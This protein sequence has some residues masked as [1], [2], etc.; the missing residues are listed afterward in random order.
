MH[1]DDTL[2]PR[3]GPH[4]PDLQPSDIEVRAKDTNRGVV[5]CTDVLLHPRASISSDM[6]CDLRAMPDSELAD[7][8]THF[9]CDQRLARRLLEDIGGPHQTVSHPESPSVA[10]TAGK[11]GVSGSEPDCRETDGSTR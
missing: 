9:G 7:G 4:S 10:V 2:E 11:E 3:L 5:S 1:Q 8:V 6:H